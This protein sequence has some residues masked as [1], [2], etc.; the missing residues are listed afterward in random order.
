MIIWI[1]FCIL[2]GLVD[3]F[4]F[5]KAYKANDFDNKVF[6]ID[7]HKFLSARRLIVLGLI[8]TNENTILQ[9]IILLGCLIL[10][11]PYIHNGVYYA[12]RNKLDKRVYKDSFF[13]TEKNDDS[14]ALIDITNFRMRF[15]LFLIGCVIFW[16][17]KLY[18]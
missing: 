17:S 9:M 1:L 2:D 5:H 12:V 18:L 6:K 8:L 13:T 16:V 7:I 11:Q 3:A 10:I 15:G 14:S 4:M